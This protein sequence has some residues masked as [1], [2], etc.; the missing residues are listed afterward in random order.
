MRFHSWRLVLVLGFVTLVLASSALRA[1]GE[2]YRRAS[3]YDPFQGP[4][5]LALAQDEVK[6]V[7][8]KLT[9]KSLKEGAKGLPGF[10]FEVR[11][12]SGSP[13]AGIGVEVKVQ[14]GA[15]DKDRHNFLLTGA[16]GGDGRVYL[17]P[18]D[19]GGLRFVR[20]GFRW[21]G[22]SRAVNAYLD[23]AGKG[24]W[25]M[26][27]APYLNPIEQQEDGECG[28][29]L[30]F[31][32]DASDPAAYRLTLTLPKSLLACREVAYGVERKASTFA[33]LDSIGRRNLNGGDKN[34]FG[35][36]YE[37]Q[38]GMEVEK[39]VR[40]EFQVIEAPEIEGYLDGM[41]EKIV[42]AS[43]APG[44]KVNLNLIHTKDVN[45]FATAGGNV[46]IFTGLITAAENESQLAG[47]MAHELEHVLSRHVTE[48]M[49]RQIKSQATVMLSTI[50]LSSA[51]DLS[52][53]QT[54]ALLTTGLLGAGLLGMKYDR[55]AETEADLVGM[56]YMWKAGYDPEGIPEFFRLLEEKYGS[57]GPG[58]LSD[59]PTHER[60]VKN[61]IFWSRAFLPESDRFLVNTTGF[62]RI[63]ELTKALPPPTKDAKEAGKGITQ[64]LAKSPSYQKFVQGGIE[65]ILGDVFFGQP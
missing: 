11:D 24:S 48:G 22:G 51:A 43:D 31:G 26:G 65:G 5:V 19:L 33:S 17:R 47:V 44:M 46:Y 28:N 53:G 25:K 45:A 21:E 58:W 39:A 60:R 32:K 42:A 18:A 8:A 54:R 49:T 62:Q 55:R 35:A 34:F 13:V 14:A 4:S 57:S 40:E 36:P 59:H 15:K 2:V 3:A 16:T 1:E 64:L 20:A 52:D 37:S 50:A 61:G 6:Q 38:M 7:V 12:A 63:Q 56:Q 10:V 27:K 9:K 41:L 23:P 29:L 30:A